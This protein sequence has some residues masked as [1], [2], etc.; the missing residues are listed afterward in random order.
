MV[1]NVLKINEHWFGS[2]YSYC[3]N[4]Q[5]FFLAHPVN[6]GTNFVNFISKF[7]VFKVIY[8]LQEA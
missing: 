3:N 7:C 8:R 2:G 6:A 4:E 1:Y 5:A